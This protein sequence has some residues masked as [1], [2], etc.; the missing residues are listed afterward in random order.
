MESR[1][2]IADSSLHNSSAASTKMP[3][4]ISTR[5]S[6]HF[7]TDIRV[8]VIP[9]SSEY[10]PEERRA[11]WFADDEINDITQHIVRTIRASQRG[12]LRHEE[13]DEE[14]LSTRGLEHMLSSEVL[15][16]HQLNKHAVTRA[17]LDAQERIRFGGNNPNP[18]HCNSAPEGILC[19]VSTQASAS[20]VQHALDQGL[21]DAEFIRMEVARSR[22]S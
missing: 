5:K 10:T 18:A 12:L 13:S 19:S 17:V 2:S 8:F 20:S 4:A 15:S 3:S 16:Q 6:V 1:H 14:V 9:D 11:Y 22:S 7:H 21:L